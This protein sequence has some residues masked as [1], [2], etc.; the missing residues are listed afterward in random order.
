MPLTAKIIDGK[1]SISTTIVDKSNKIIAQIVDNQ[2]RVNPNNSFQRN[3]DDNAVEVIDEQGDVALSVELTN[4]DTVQIQGIFNSQTKDALVIA[5]KLT[6]M[7]ILAMDAQSIRN[8]EQ[9]EGKSWKEI[10]HEYAQ[11]IP[12]LFVYIGKGFLSK[13]V[14]DKE[15]E[16]K[17][18]V[19]NNREDKFSKYNSEN[20]MNYLGEI[21][22]AHYSK[23]GVIPDNETISKDVK[24][25]EALS[26]PD[27]ELTKIIDEEIRFFRIKEM[28]KNRN[29]GKKD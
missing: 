2:W 9:L 16:A 12:K 19:V 10:Y 7:R 14:S 26:L 4:A 20:I 23:N 17:K 3:Y 22:E 1:L 27:G 8:K 21:I 11:E 13:R 29:Q 6:G 18:I 5:S 25:N 24:L 15:L 28:M